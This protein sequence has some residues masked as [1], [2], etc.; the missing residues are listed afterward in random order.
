M[1]GGQE[2]N[3]PRVTKER[4][5]NHIQQIPRILAEIDTPVIA[6]V[7]GVA[8][9]AGMDLASMCDMRI[10]AESARFA[11]SYVKIGL[12]PGAGGAYFLPRIV[13]QAKAMELLL[14]GE[15][16]D[17]QEAYRVGYVN[18]VYP[19]EQL[20]DKTY[21]FAERIASNAPL[22]IR[23]IK[24]AMLQG[25]NIDLRT[26]LDQI[27]SHMTVVRSSEDHAEAVVAFKEKRPAK[28]K[29]R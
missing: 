14:T 3:S 8:A 1:G 6:A 26:H 4:L 19:D 27:S 11:E 13:G 29:G 10:A 18:Y 9:G 22:S 17:A 25:L 21:E 7:N 16:I 2:A 15:F 5:W 28:F 12:V 24:R 23:L 20:V